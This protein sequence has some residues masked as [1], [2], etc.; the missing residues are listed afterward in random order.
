MGKQNRLRRAARRRSK[1]QT[2]GGT[3]RQGAR[4]D[5]GRYGFAGE[6]GASRVSASSAPPPL[7]LDELFAA[8]IYAAWARRGD[9]PA[10]V[11]HLTIHARRDDARVSS[12][13]AQQLT[14]AVGECWTR[15]W[16]PAD[17]QHVVGRLLQSTH[18]QVC[19]LAIA[20]DALSYRHEPNA[21]PAWLA[22]VAAVA[23]PDDEAVDGSDLLD[24]CTAITH[25]I[26][27]ALELVVET[28]ARLHN[29][30][31]QPRLCAPPS[32]W[33]RGPQRA[34]STASARRPVGSTAPDPKMIERV[35]ALL[36]KAES[37]DFPDEAE[38][39][40]AKAQEL[41]ARHAID[42]A[43]LEGK[44]K[45]GAPSQASGR[46][47]LLDDPYAKA[48]SLLLSAIASANH[49][50]A[51]RNPGFGICTVFGATSDLDAVEMLYASLLTQATAAMVREG[52]SGAHARS[53]GFRNSF[54]T[55][56]GTRIGQRLR[57][58]TNTAI[59][60]A[61]AAHGKN[62]LPVLAS[63]DEAADAACD[64]AFPRVRHERISTSNLSGWAAGYAA[65][66]L[67]RLGPDTELRAG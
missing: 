13:L 9:L 2:T 31:P 30:P 39:F 66:D 61:Q 59:D 23:G 33:A 5:G 11:D 37:T 64:A 28:L 60:E 3:P 6:P 44:G 49:C 47:V 63:R 55:A 26:P 25:D 29:L 48:K 36:A 42:M 16:Q 32:E 56:Y 43:M 53:R 4:R 17:L 12:V 67:A 62:V 57:D 21:D 34:A 8:A 41:I 52:R 65:A 54:L 58:A 27:T 50:R 24:R 22:Q 38:T 7:P 15:G 35:R 1:R 46:R 20:L 10:L 40:T 14:R 51:V 18:R 19:G 45:P